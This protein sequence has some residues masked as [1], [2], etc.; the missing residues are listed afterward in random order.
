MKKLFIMFAL[1]MVVFTSLVSA[2]SIERVELNDDEVLSV[3][4]NQVRSFVKDDLIKIEVQVESATVAKNVQIEAVISGME[5]DSDSVRDVTPVFDMTAG[6]RYKKNLEIYLPKRMQSD[7]SYRL[8]IRVEDQINPGVYADYY[9]MVES[10]HRLVEVTD[11]LL[12]PETEIISGQA[13]LV[14]PMLE[15]FGKR[16]EKDIKVVVSIPELGVSVTGIMDE[17]DDGDTGLLEPLFLKIPQCA[18]EGVYNML[19]DTYYNDEDDKSST[20]SVVRVVTSDSCSTLTQIES[21]KTTEFVAKYEV[22]QAPVVVKNDF[23]IVKTSVWTTVLQYS[24][25]GLAVLIIILVIVFIVKQA[26]KEAMDD[27]EF[28]KE[29]EGNN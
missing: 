19:I 23:K 21:Q 1:M 3:G 15:N 28:L 20:S 26:K 29:L 16:S 10:E 9:L 7:E 5:H 6:I 4:N 13:L 24:L 18:E 22:E 11:V 2:Y 17:L 14:Q 25:M 12:S 8:R 27:E